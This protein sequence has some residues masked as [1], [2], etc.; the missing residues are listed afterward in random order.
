M[1]YRM[2][3]GRD[4]PALHWAPRQPRG[5]VALQR[6]PSRMPAPRETVTGAEAGALAWARACLLLPWA[7]LTEDG[8]S[9]P[10]CGLA[11]MLVK[12]SPNFKLFLSPHAVPDVAP[13][14]TCFSLSRSHMWKKVCIFLSIVRKL[15]FGV[16]LIIS[17]IIFPVSLVFALIVITLTHRL[18]LG[19][20]SFGRPARRCCCAVSS[21][22]F[23]RE[24]R[25]FLA[26]ISASA[27]EK[28]SPFVQ[29]C[30]IK[31]FTPLFITK[32]KLKT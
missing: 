32:K 25:R 21:S 3:M 15:Q 13:S 31:I 18:E 11:K 6:H 1:P 4:S 12:R 22:G 26:H 2:H 29:K 30:C 14:T 24:I 5:D 19:L 7:Q 23:Q 8:G 28:D 27:L 9:A 20:F 16:L 17:T 10:P